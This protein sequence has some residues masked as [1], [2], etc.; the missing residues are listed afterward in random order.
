[1][2]CRWLFRHNLEF[3]FVTIYLPERVHTHMARVNSYKAHDWGPSYFIVNM[4]H[5]VH[6]NYVASLFGLYLHGNQTN[7]ASQPQTL[8]RLLKGWTFCPLPDSPQAHVYTV[9]QTL[10]SVVMSDIFRR[11]MTSWHGNV[12][13]ITGLCEGV[14]RLQV[15][16]SNKK[17]QR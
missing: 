9:N 12:F 16:S 10:S 14:H 6:G 15:H 5:W 8:Y 1:M 4:C 3:T 7:T 13:C 11:M 2:I 17:K